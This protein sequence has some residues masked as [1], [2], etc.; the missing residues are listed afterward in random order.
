MR[1]EV[2]QT[3]FEAYKFPLLNLSAPDTMDGLVIV[4]A[5]ANRYTDADIEIIDR[6]NGINQV[7]ACYF[8]GRT[9]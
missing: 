5:I 2:D 4:R 7:F 1:I 3:S 9:F 8:Y 6:F